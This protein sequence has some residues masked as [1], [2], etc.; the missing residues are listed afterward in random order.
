MLKC[1]RYLAMTELAIAVILL[2]LS[3]LATALP[4]DMDN[5]YESYFKYKASKIEIGAYL[6]IFASS[7]YHII[8]L[9]GLFFQKAWAGKHYVYSSAGLLIPTLVGPP[10][11]MTSWAFGI[12]QIATAIMGALVA[13]LIFL[14]VANK[15]SGDY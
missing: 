1:V 14:E 2:V 12:D 15:R 7:I 5:Y 8:C 3:S 6:I 11:V 9:L 10:V 13:I 4:Q